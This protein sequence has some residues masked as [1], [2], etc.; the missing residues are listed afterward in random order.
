MKHSW[1]VLVLLAAACATPPP[2]PEILI[3]PLA[4]ET[5]AFHVPDVSGE[6][7]T[8]RYR[9]KA[10][11]LLA[12]ASDLALRLDSEAG[13]GYAGPSKIP[14][15]DPK[16]AALCQ[17]AQVIRDFV[18]PGSWEGDP[19]RTVYVEKDEIVVRH[20]PAVLERVERLLETL[21]A[22]RAVTLSLRARFV[23]IP[24]EEL[25]VIEHLPMVRGG[26]GG[27]VET[28][29][30]QGSALTGLRPERSRHPS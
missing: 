4:S 3:R 15:G 11:E 21:K 24:A 26:L 14:S 16:T 12:D 29:D 28:K 5:S 17:A 2:P 8:R 23:S 6:P 18:A 9:I 10:E 20:A 27:V 30:L 7:E 13:D 19:R 25:A 1:S 22:N